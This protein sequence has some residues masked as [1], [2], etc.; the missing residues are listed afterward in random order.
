M[1]VH[2]WGEETRRDE[3][4]GDDDGDTAGDRDENADGDS[5]EDAR[6]FNDDDADRDSD[7]DWDEGKDCVGA[8]GGGAVCA[9]W[10]PNLGACQSP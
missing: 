1:M 7:E 5:D 4:G 8:G 9:A 2:C 6:E 10:C 3:E